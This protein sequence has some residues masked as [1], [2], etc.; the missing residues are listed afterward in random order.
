MYKR[1]YIFVI[2]GLL[3][4]PVGPLA[5]LSTIFFFGGLYSMLTG[6]FESLTI[7]PVLAG[8]PMGFSGLVLTVLNKNGIWFVILLICGCASYITYLYLGGMNGLHWAAIGWYLP[9]LVTFPHFY[10]FVSLRYVQRNSN[11]L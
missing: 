1:I 8:A 3:I 11:A 4:F 7:M 2:V 10:E 5:L 9:V 6:N